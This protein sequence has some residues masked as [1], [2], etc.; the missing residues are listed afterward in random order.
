M[1]ADKH[2]GRQH[3]AIGHIRAI[4][5]KAAVA[6][7]GGAQRHP[8]AFY[9]VIAQHHG[10]GNKGFIAQR[11]HVWHYAHGGRYFGAFTY[12][13]PHEPIPIGRKYRGINRVQRV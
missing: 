12:F 1:H 13:C 6:N 3:R 8:A 11:K 9:V 10:V 2:I 5:N 7:G 4:A